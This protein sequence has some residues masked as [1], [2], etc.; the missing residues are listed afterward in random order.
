MRDKPV[1]TDRSTMPIDLMEEAGINFLPLL[2]TS[3]RTQASANH[4]IEDAMGHD[5]LSLPINT[6]YLEMDWHLFELTIAGEELK[7]QQ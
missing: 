2:K 1:D 4:H 7:D 5:M 6:E 3:L